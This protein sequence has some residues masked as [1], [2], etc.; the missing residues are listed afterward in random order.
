MSYNDQKE[1]GDRVSKEFAEA[2]MGAWLQHLEKVVKQNASPSSPVAGGPAVTYAD[3]VLYHVL[4]ATKEQFNSEFY[5]MAWD[6]A[7]IPCLKEFHAWM[8]TRPNIAAYHSS[9]RL[10]PFSGNSMM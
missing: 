9:D 5:G 3:F 8:E 10:V 4:D 1:E 7:D 2:R 6:S